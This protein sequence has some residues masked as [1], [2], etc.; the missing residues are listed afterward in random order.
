VVVLRASL[1]K[2]VALDAPWL[3]MAALGATLLGISA[4]RFRKSLD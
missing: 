3:A 1:L 4:L 2:A